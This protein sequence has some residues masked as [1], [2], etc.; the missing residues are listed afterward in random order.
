MVLRTGRYAFMEKNKMISEREKLN[1]IKQKL[2]TEKMKRRAVIFNKYSL[3][4]HILIACGVCFLIEWVSRHSF[5]EACVFV[6]DRN[7]AFLYNS[8]LI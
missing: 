4:F 6:V 1:Q 3:L 5:V 7:L 2:N 8:L